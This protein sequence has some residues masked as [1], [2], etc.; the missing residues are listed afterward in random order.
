MNKDLMNFTEAADDVCQMVKGINKNFSY[1]VPP[2]SIGVTEDALQAALA[3][4][5]VDLDKLIETLRRI[6]NAYCI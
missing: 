2:L 6:N 1:Y 3:L 4:Q 5:V